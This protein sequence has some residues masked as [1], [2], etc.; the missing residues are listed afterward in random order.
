[1]NNLKNSVLDLINKVDGLVGLYIENLTTREIIEFNSKERFHAA[2]TIK[3]PILLEGLRQVENET[4]S[5]GD[6]IYLKEEDKVG[7]CGVLS[8][9]HSNIEM[10]FEDLL[11]LMICV[12]DNTATNMLIDFIGI[13]NVNNM[14]E[15]F[16]FENTYLARKLMIVIPGKYSYT[17]AY[18]MGKMLKMISEKS[19]LG[20]N[21]SELALSILKKQQL[22][23]GFSRDLNLCGKCNFMV[24][25]ENICENCNSSMSDVDFIH[26]DFP[27]KT[28]EIVGV[29]HDM[30][31][32]D[33]NGEKI[34]MVGLT[35]GLKNNIVG[36]EL[37]S[38]IGKL[39]YDYYRR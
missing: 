28:G 17:S 14:L 32:L 1:M 35:K 30:G 26:I 13:D 36:H 39:V 12:S 3:V 4:K 31:I 9:L 16:N 15:E 34:V 2:S 6:K 25:Y 21:Y 27:H 5:L 18:D 10:T 20:K 22:V 38:D 7:G 37:L 33:L 24:E 19:I 8:L 29:V 11:N 23:N